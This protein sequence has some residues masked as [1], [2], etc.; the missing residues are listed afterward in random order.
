M[1]A[2]TN[3]VLTYKYI[4]IVT[5]SGYIYVCLTKYIHVYISMTVST[6]PISSDTMYT[7]RIRVRARTTRSPYQIMPS[8][9]IKYK[10]APYVYICINHKENIIGQRFKAL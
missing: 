8:F 2:Y 4:F 10:L 1:V 9:K 3:I 7:C 6:T 5:A